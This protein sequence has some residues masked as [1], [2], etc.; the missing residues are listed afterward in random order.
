MAV[1]GGRRG[2]VV[3]VEETVGEYVAVAA[4]RVIEGDKEG[5]RT[6]G[7]SS[8][9]FWRLA[10]IFFGTSIVVAAGKEPPVLDVMDFGTC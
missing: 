1:L 9:S 3:E 5:A 2:P 6:K 4:G 7:S 8:L 10:S